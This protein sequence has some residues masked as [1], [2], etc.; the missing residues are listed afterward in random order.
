MLIRQATCEGAEAVSAMILDQVH[1]IAL[2]PAGIGA[3]GV[4]ASMRADSLVENFTSP[5][6]RYWV[7]EDQGAIHGALGL[8]DQSHLYQL[9]VAKNQ[10]R[11]G[12]G[13]RLWL[14]M[15]DALKENPPTAITVNASPYGLP[16]YESLGFVRQGP[17]VEMNGIA[18]IPMKLLF[19][20][21]E[22]TR[23]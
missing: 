23:P 14:H 15:L 17:R 12:I 20:T 16:A 13:K 7:A 2:H 19:P 4:L 18:L 9:F 6:F 1:L 11:Q 10:H 3:E 5:R 22:R 21:Q 8:R